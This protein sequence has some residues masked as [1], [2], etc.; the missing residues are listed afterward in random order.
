MN[1]QIPKGAKEGSDTPEQSNSLVRHTRFR[2]L[3]AFIAI[4]ATVS[5]IFAGTPGDADSRKADY[6]FLEASQAFED[7]RFDD[8]FYLLRRAQTLLPNDTFIAARIAEIQLQLTADSATTEKAYDA[9]KTRFYAEPTN[10]IYARTF[11]SVANSMRRLDDVIDAWQTLDS[12]EPQRTDPAFN[13]ATSLLARYQNGLDTT[14]YNRGLAILD[15][16]ENATGPNTQL[17]YNKVSA[18]LLRNDTAAILRQLDKLGK[19]APAD[20]SAQLL[21]GN[22]FE[23][24]GKPDSALAFYNRAAAID[25]E[26][27][28]VYLSRAEFFRNRGDSVAYD[29]EVF[30]ALESQELPFDEKF[31]LLTGYVQK[32]YTDTAQWNRI[33]QMFG[34]LQQ[35]NPGEAEL[36]D[37]YASYLSAI[38]QKEEAAE[39]LSYSMDLDPSDPRRWDDLVM[40]YFNTDDTVRAEQTSRKGL[41]MYP[42]RGTFQYTLATAQMMRGKTEEALE[43]LDGIDT[44]HLSNKILESTLHASRGDILSKLGLNDDAAREYKKAIDLNPDNY[45][46]MNNWAYFNAVS[47]TDL[48]NSELYAS[49]ACAAQPW[50]ETFLDTYAWVLFKKKDY[51]KAREVIDKALAVY[52][53]APE[54]KK[55]EE[56]NPA[57]VVEDST[58]ADISEKTPSA[59]VFDH[60]G[61]IY[62]WNQLPEK[63][64]EFWKKA[65]ELDPGNELIQKKVKQGTYFFE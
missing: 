15:R 36:H 46:A 59:E 29:R 31:R 55:P 30:R 39:Q 34:V 26:D 22:V 32:L 52:G 23:H 38:G 18:Y 7:N 49:I 1:S 58:E 60:A 62:F 24:L 56:I 37:F 53:I 9:L 51:A 19:S 10:D 6:I 45:M 40:L 41:E 12:L 65:L 64:R 54:G 47:N 27:G 50:N 57:I 42:E 2:L 25:P 33:G 43:T 21:I 11:I 4:A 5:V 20:I 48:D 14:D 28:M 35:I 44:L 13:L 61:D 3:P 8:Y 63:S 17:T 16:L